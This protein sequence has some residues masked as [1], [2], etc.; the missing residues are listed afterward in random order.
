VQFE[1]GDGSKALFLQ[2]VWCGESTLKILFRA[3]FNTACT[4]EIWVE[5]NM[6]IANGV[7]HW[8]VMFIRPVH[9][10]EMEKVSRFFELLYSQQVKHGGVDKICWIPSKRKNFEVKSYYQ[11]RV[12]SVLTD[13]PWKSKAPSRVAFFVW[14]VVLGKILTSDNICK[15]NIMVTKWCCMCKHSGESIDHLL[16]HSEVAIKLWNMVCQMF[17][18]TWVMPGRMKECLESWRGQRS[19][20]TIRHIWRMAHLCVMWCLSRERNAQSFED[21]EL[22]LIELKKR[23]SKLCSHVELCGIRRKLQ[24]FWNF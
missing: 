5:E 9:D 20:H 12:N 6:D 15:K 11:V 3:L 16:L 18:I 2:D 1:V 7:I 4:K 10:W 14:K 23:C 21:C 19:N 8:N 24:H 22:G 17:G 13:G